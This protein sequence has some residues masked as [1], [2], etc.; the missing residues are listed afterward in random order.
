M[1]LKRY[2]GN[3]GEPPFSSQLTDIIYCS[4]NGMLWRRP[5]DKEMCYLRCN[6]DVCRL[7][8]VYIVFQLHVLKETAIPNTSKVKFYFRCNQMSKKYIASC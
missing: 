2:K 6:G 1:M 4:W 8:L 5:R 3:D 7:T